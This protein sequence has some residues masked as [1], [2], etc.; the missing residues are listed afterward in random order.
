MPTGSITAPLTP[1]DEHVTVYNQGSFTAYIGTSGDDAINGSYYIDHIFGG[2]GNDTLDRGGF[3]D[4]LVGGAGVDTL[5][6]SA[7]DR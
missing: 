2:A 6:G 7:A 4:T 3:I 5:T 1:S